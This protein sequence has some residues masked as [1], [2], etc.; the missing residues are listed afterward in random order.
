[1]SII[2]VSEEEFFYDIEQKDG[3]KVVFQIGFLVCLASRGR[4]KKSFRKLTFRPG[5]T[6]F[7]SECLTMKRKFKKIFIVLFD[8]VNNSRVFSPFSFSSLFP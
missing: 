5:R 1:M 4:K 7:S 2:S 6:I 8:F 3:M